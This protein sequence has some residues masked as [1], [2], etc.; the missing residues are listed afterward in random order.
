MEKEGRKKRERREKEEREKGG[1][2]GKQQKKK[3]KRWEKEGRKTGERIEKEKRKKGERRENGMKAPL[4]ILNP[5][6][7]K[8]EDQRT[9]I[10]LLDGKYCTVACLPGVWKEVSRFYTK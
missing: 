3:R 4:A 7:L 10:G 8:E 1:R 9:G 6:Q 2:R 5:V